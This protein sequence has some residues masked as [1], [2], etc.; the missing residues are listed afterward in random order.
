MS[1]HYVHYTVETDWQFDFFSVQMFQVDLTQAWRRFCSLSALRSR[2]KACFVCK[3]RV[4]S[5]ILSCTRLPWKPWLC[6]VGCVRDP[7]LCSDPSL[8]WWHTFP[9]GI[10]IQHLPRLLYAKGLVDSLLA[11]KASHAHLLRGSEVTTQAWPGHR[12]LFIT[13]LW[14][15]TLRLKKAPYWTAWWEREAFFSHIFFFGVA[16]ACHCHVSAA[17]GNRRRGRSLGCLWAACCLA[18]P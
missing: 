15:R 12:C 17:C 9:R 18:G 8:W 6:C 4:Y 3:P 10:H 5:P 13:I 7:P 2:L 16:S 14:R 1:Y 11:I